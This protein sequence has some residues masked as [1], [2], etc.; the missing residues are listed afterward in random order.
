MQIF[1]NTQIHTLENSH[2]KEE[3]HRACIHVKRDIPF[4]EWAD[5]FQ[6]ESIFHIQF[7]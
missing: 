5:H 6:M 4:C 1:E 2:K 7:L 3:K